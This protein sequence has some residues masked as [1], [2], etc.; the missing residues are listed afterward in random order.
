MQN[1]AFDD[2]MREVKLQHREMLRKW[3]DETKDD[4]RLESSL[5]KYLA[6]SVVRDVTAWAADLFGAA[7][8]IFDHPIH[9]FPM[10]AWASSLGEDTQDIQ[11]LVIFREIIKRFDQ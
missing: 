3:L 11:K 2:S 4:F 7:S 1:L 10:D 6:V 9:K 8:V 5:A